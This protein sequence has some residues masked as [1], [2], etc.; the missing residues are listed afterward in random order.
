MQWEIG[1]NTLIV[2]SILED[3][4]SSRN[5]RKPILLLTPMSNDF[6]NE[7]ITPVRSK[8]IAHIFNINCN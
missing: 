7:A 1:T 3:I 4:G 8:L 6:Q 5:S 2:L